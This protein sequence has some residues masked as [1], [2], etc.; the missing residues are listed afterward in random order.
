MLTMLCFSLSVLGVHIV[1]FT[2]EGNTS[3]GVDTFA[4]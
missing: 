3:L 1:R 4:K 2:K